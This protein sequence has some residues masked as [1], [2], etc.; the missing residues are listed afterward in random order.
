MIIC[1]SVLIRVR[2]VSAETCRE[3]RNT[4][5]MFDFFSR[6]SLRLYVEKYC[7]DGQATACGL[8]AGYLRLQTHT[9]NM[10]TNTYC[11]PTATMDA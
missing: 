11:F 1:R 2:N 4:H 8:Y 3:N 5:F 6:K 7:K 9:Q 10:W